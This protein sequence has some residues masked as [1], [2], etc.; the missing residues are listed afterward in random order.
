M[1]NM[2]GGG[3]TALSLGFV[4]GQLS[5]ND[6]E[7]L[8]KDQAEQGLRTN[9]GYAKL[10]MSLAR[11]QMISQA[12]TLYA[13]AYGQ[14]SN[15]NLSSSEQLSLA[16][17][18]AVRA[19][20][21]SESCADQGVIAT[22]ELRYLFDSTGELPG[23][24]ELSAFVDHGYAALHNTPLPDA[25]KNTSNLTGAGFGVKWF[26][27]KNYSLQS[28]AAWKISGASSPSESPMV[29]AQAIKSF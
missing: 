21:T 14:W 27:A 28:T 10:N 24:L 19:W 15:K 25:G 3:S 23:K 12:L 5:L 8:S 16:G 13:G 4:R 22:A 29:Y 6:A 1:D 18:G 20:Q 11:T 7:T 2:L 26:D 9:G 17:P